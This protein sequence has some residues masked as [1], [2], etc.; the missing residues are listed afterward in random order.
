MIKLHPAYDSDRDLYRQ[1]IGGDPR[2]T[3]EPETSLA[4][5]QDLIAGADLHLS[6][7]SACHFDA[8]GIGT[9]TGVLA[10]ETHQSVQ[11][12][13]KER[14]ALLIETPKELAH[15]VAERSF[16]S[17]PEETSDRFFRR[18]F[19]RN[20]EKLIVSLE[21]AGVSDGVDRT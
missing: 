2:V 4:S 6:I 19:E 14:G 21:T 12:I 13:L 8:L 20:I 7:S 9:P 18:D 11:G 16:P 17:V 5:T 3:I 10:L 1:R 15:I